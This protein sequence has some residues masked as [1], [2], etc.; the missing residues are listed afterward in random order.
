MVRHFFAKSAFEGT[1]VMFFKG[2][3]PYQFVLILINLYQMISMFMLCSIPLYYIYFT[4]SVVIKLQLQ[5]SF[6]ILLLICSWIETSIDIHSLLN[7]LIADYYTFL[8]IGMKHRSSMVTC[9]IESFMSG[10][11]YHT[12]YEFH[13]IIPHYFSETRLF[14]LFYFTSTICSNGINWSIIGLINLNLLFYQSIRYGKNIHILNII[15]HPI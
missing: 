5:Y 15:M 6:A 11:E 7:N 1:I 2:R 12:L 3:C 13:I 14:W 10:F 9:M 4:S 8:M